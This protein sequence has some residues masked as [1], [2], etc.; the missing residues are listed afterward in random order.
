MDRLT[1]LPFIFNHVVLP[2]RLPGRSDSENTVLETKRE[3]TRRL[4]LAAK[5][6]KCNTNKEYFPT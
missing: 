2:P 4:L 1:V 3:L 5:T 6:V